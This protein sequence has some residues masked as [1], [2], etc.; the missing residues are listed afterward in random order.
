MSGAVTSIA[1]SPSVVLSTALDRYTR[2]HS[3]FP[4]PQTIGQQQ[5]H[6]GDVLEKIFMKTIPTVVVWD[7][8]EVADPVTSVSQT[9]EDDVWEK[10]EHVEDVDTGRIKRARLP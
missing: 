6:K 4:P 8:D 9:D 2:V 3:N 1:P 5:E 10:M 7:Q